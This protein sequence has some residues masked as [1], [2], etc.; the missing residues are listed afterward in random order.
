MRQIG[1]DR[2]LFVQPFDHRG[3]FTKGFFGIAGRPVRID[4]E[5]DEH[6]QVAD[7]K[8]LVYRGLLRAID[9]GVPREQVGILCDAQFGSQILADARAK[10]IPTAVCIEK[11]GQDVFD[12]EYG[13]RWVDHVRFIAPAMIKV[14]VRYHPD[15]DPGINR[16]QLARLK[17]VSEYVHSTDD[18]WFMFELLVPAMTEADKAAG[19][20]FDAE[21]RPRLVIE[22]IRQI[23]SFGVEPDIWKIEGLES[24][25]DARAIAAQVRTGAGREKAACILLGRGSDKESVH[26][27]LRVAAPIDGYVGFAVGRT[28]FSAPL[29]AY[30]QSRT[31]EAAA[32]AIETIARNFKECVDV[33]RQAAGG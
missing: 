30:I 18:C 33:W 14:L 31:P 8:T 2:P 25:A 1:Y 3:S 11:S 22:A 10:G 5:V 15:D 7:A 6:A 26:R 9:L 24:A 19:D 12:F 28:N 20:R 17:Q 13:G 23:Q 32:T 4:A 21:V 29:K 27:W 16:E